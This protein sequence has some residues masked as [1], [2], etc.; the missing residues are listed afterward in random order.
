VIIILTKHAQEKKINLLIFWLFMRTNVSPD[1][2][3][4]RHSYQTNDGCSNANERAGRN[5]NQRQFPTPVKSQQEPKE[6]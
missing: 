2:E 6:G 5:N 1:R 3:A 4:K